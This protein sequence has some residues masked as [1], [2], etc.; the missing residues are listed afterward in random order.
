MSVCRLIAD[1]KD[2]LGEG[3]VLVARENALRW[4]DIFGR[5]W[6]RFD[7]ATG[8]LRTI[9]LSE[10][11]TAFAPRRSGGFVGTF[12]SGFAFVNEDAA[13]IS[14]LHRPETTLADNR[15][16]DGGTDP[17]GRFLAGS[18]NKVGG[19]ATGSLYHLDAERRLTLLRSGIGISNTIAFSPDGRILYFA[20]TAA[21]DLGA[22]AYD[23]ES[24]SLG[25]RQHFA[26]PKDV[27]GYPDGSAVDTE[28]YLW[29]ARWD[30]WCVVRFAPDGRVDRIVELPVQRP[31]SCAFGPAGSTTL[32]IT[33][34]AFELKGDELARQPW[35]GGLLAI[36]A[37]VTGVPRPLFEG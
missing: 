24:G 30:G 28:G 23:L 15:F 33:S 19:G 5:R 26:V 3:P 27:P 21:G 14:W 16:N 35:A 9:P 10:G 13:E 37:G 20:D 34:A 2:E 29:N 18:M 6:H 32:Y 17:R 1:T 12:E 25:A 11:L 4:V 22:Y 31:T 8:A 7:L 36:D